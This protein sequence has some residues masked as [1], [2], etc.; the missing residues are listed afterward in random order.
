VPC[1][2]DFFERREAK[3]VEKES[4]KLLEESNARENRRHQLEMLSW[5]DAHFHS[6]RIW[7]DS[8][9]LCISEAR[10]FVCLGDEYNG[11]KTS[12][13][14]RLSSLID[15]GRWYFPNIQDE[16]YGRHKEPAYRGFRQPVL[17]YVVDAYIALESTEDRDVIVAKLLTCQRLFVSDIQI[18]INPR[19]REA[20]FEHF[21]KSMPIPERAVASGDSNTLRA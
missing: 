13:M 7:A 11:Q 12:V 18:A 3:R 14:S 15:T 17:D 10:H 8:V 6:V 1:Y 21:L 2:L 19:R 4:Q 5:R 9:C 16:V 20:E